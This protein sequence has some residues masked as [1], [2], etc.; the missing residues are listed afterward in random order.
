MEDI[1]VPRKW[2]KSLLALSEQ[3][4]KEMDN[5]NESDKP[6]MP[7]VMSKLIGY[8]S[9]AKSLLAKPK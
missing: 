7:M 8:S 9:S 6:Y 3:A 4:N 5:W 1:K 2:L